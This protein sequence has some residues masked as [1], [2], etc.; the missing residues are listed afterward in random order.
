VRNV[1]IKVY[2]K[3]FMII[4]KCYVSQKNTRKLPTVKLEFERKGFYF[5]GAKVYFELLN[6]IRQFGIITTKKKSQQP[7]NLFPFFSYK[8]LKLFFRTIY[9]REN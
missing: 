4:L 6:E 8:C 2:V 1:W 3:S 7:P 5:F 9:F